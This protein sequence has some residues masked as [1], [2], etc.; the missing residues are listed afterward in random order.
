MDTTHTEDTTVSQH[1]GIEL[2]PE[3]RQIRLTDDVW[4]RVKVLAARQDKRPSQIVQAALEEYIAD[5]VS[6]TA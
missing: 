4:K 2:R 1:S 5:R 6:Q 3:R